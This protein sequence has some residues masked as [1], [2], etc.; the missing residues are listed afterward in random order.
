MSS[1][2]LKLLFAVSLYLSGI[3]ET[4]AQYIEFGVKVTDMSDALV[5]NGNLS[6]GQT[7]K[8]NAFIKSFDNGIDFY[9]VE[10]TLKLSFSS[11]SSDATFGFIQSTSPNGIPDTSYLFQGLVMSREDLMHISR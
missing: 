9:N 1:K 5:T 2:A 7:Y 4:H 6:I 10:A 8:I 3:S 11:A